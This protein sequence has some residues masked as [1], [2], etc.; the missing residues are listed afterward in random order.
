M[1]ESWKI[2]YESWKIQIQQQTLIFEV[3]NA[4]RKL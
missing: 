4:F 3:K 2:Q 1:Y